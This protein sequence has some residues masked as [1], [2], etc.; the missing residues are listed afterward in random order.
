MRLLPPGHQRHREQCFEVE[1]KR[2]DSAYR[3]LQREHHP[4]KHATHTEV[5]LPNLK[6]IAAATLPKNNRSE[7][8]CQI[9]GPDIL[10]EQ[11]KLEIYGLHVTF[12]IMYQIRS[13]MLAQEE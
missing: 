8:S 10:L 6:Q 11:V 2:L 1:A 9:C 5:L 13:C 3:A 4:D 7:H 12:P